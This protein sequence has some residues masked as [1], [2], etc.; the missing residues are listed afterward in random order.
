VHELLEGAA[1]VL[2]AK[3]PKRAPHPDLA[4]RLER[5][6][7][8]QANTEYAAMMGDVRGTGGD[9]DKDS[10]IA[11]YKTQIGVRRTTAPRSRG[12][13]ARPRADG[14]CG[15]GRLART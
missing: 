2:P 12:C 7:A 6:R 9:D 8:A 10:E 3:P 5:L 14:L 1:P 4:P 11:T 13:R 15:R